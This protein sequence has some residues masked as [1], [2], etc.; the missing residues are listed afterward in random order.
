MGK[1]L[2]QDYWEQRYQDGQTQWDAGQ[3]T[4]PIK[5]YIDGLVD[6]NQRIL[7]PGAGNAHEAEYLYQKGFKNTYV[8][9]WA[10]KALTQFS[11]RVPD[12]PK[13]QLLHVNFFELEQKF[14]CI[15]EQTFFCAIQPNLRPAY[16]QKMAQLLSENGR[17]VGLFFAN[18]FE[19]EGPPFG[20][21]KEEYLTYF[22]PY[23]KIKTMEACYNSIPPRLGSELF[24]ELR[25][26]N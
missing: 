16:A 2:D 17:L 8:C 25:V 3:I 5:E 1:K 4:T 13:A 15:I 20:G 14:D 10:A 23:F 6:K 24:V 18:E 22:K 19:R 21:T 7:I 9:D 11:E 12:F 26:E